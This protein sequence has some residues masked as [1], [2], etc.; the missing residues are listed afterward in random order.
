MQTQRRRFLA[1]SLVIALGA[2][3]SVFSTGCS[4]HAKLA[5]EHS[6]D[7]T[8]MAL[9]TFTRDVEQVRKG[10]PEGAKILGARM[11]ADP[12]GN[13]LELQT[14]IKAARDNVKD[15]AYA[16]STFFSFAGTDG[17]V[18]R[19]EIDPDRLVD[20][21]VLTVFP[22]LKKALEPG[23]GLVEA[24]GEMDALRGVKKGN[25]IAWIV[26]HAVPGADG[27][28][29]GLFLSGWSI[30]LYIGFVQDAVRSK[31]D[32]KTKDTSE[33]VEAYLYLVKGSG[34]YGHPDAP[35]VHAE[36]LLKHDLVNK[37]KNGDY[38]AKVELEDKTWG[39][40]AKKAPQFGD[41][42][43]IAAISTIY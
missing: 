1:M 29:Q 2:T 21:N 19:S 30:R 6:S 32:T 34:A 9:E 39:I 25:D 41:D 33:K 16:K 23:A 40:V 10:M 37:V 8:N 36:E 18:L 14:S 11:P 17:V 28:P 43:V 4:D 35:D 24:Y 27:K 3:S 22:D 26:A 12:R 15:L 5:Q 20:Q 7:A 13:R 38:R 31:L 42:A